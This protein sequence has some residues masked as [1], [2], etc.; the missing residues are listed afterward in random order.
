MGTSADDAALN[1]DMVAAAIRADAADTRTFMEALAVKLE[2]AL[3]GQVAIEREGGLFQK[4]HRV[5]RISVDLQDRHY[6]LERIHSG[7]EAR[8]AHQ[9]RGIKLKTDVV[10]LPEWIDTLAR[11]LATYAESNAQARAALARLVD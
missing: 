3:P 1:F 2:E 4:E 9:V 5:K 11:H 10:P 7:V 8:T 6:E